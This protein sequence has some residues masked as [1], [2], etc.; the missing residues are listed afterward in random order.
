MWP[1]TM[2]EIAAIIADM[3]TRAE[4]H[5][6]TLRFGYRTH[7]VVRETESDARARSGCGAVIVADHVLPALRA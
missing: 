7:V 2:P 6:R 3:R 5:G 1:D 4:R